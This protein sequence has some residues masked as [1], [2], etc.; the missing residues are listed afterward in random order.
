MNSRPTVSLL[1]PNHNGAPVLDEVLE[2]LVEHASYPRTE[3]IAVDDGSSDDSRVILRRWRDTGLLDAFTL[4]EKEKSGAIDTLNAALNAASGEICVQLDSDATVETAGWVE[5]MLELMLLDDMV[6]VVTARVVMDSGSLHACGVNVVH[7][8]GWHDRPARVTEPP[9]HRRWHH[10]LDRPREG[11]GGDAE[12]RVAEV[13]AGIGCCMMYRREDAL[14]VGGYDRGYAPVWFDD[15]DLCLSIRTLG[16]KAFCLPDVR[17]V[18][19][20]SRR[21][22]AEPPR[23]RVDTR[24]VARAA[25]RRIAARLPTS[26]RS[27]IERRFGVD[28]EMN[29]SSAQRARLRHH[30]AYWRAKWGW[31]PCNPDMAA[32]RR[33]WG[34]SE[35]CWA[36]EPERRAAGE[37]IAGTYEAVRGVE[38]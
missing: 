25:T 5:R 18:H 7:P 15:V 8:A 22:L 9:G 20:L 33:R 38:A 13:D 12:R 28:L 17:V 1:L 29:Y 37:R 19:H 32:I 21:A 34:G 3:L 6:G 24:R 14:A 31:D 26:A 11:Q 30:Y 23:S 36:S 16:R 27:G 4:I 10:R 2:R 35:I